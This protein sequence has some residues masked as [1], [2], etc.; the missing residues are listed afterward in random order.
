MNGQNI[1]AVPQKNRYDESIQLL[2]TQ[3]KNT[4]VTTAT[5]QFTSSLSSFLK[6]L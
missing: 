1:L 3:P 5:K 2:A 4:I 6:K